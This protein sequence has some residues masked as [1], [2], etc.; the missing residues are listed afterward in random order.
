MFNTKSVPGKYYNWLCIFNVLF[1]VSC[2][3]VFLVGALKVFHCDNISYSCFISDINIFYRCT[4]K[5][6]YSVRIMLTII[7]DRNHTSVRLESKTVIFSFF[8]FSALPLIAQ[9]PA[10]THV[11]SGSN[12]IFECGVRGN[13]K[14]TIFWSLQTNDTVLFPN[15]SWNE[16]H[17]ED[18]KDS[19]STLVV[20]VSICHALDEFSGAPN[21]R[22]QKTVDETV[23][24]HFADVIWLKKK[25]KSPDN[26][27]FPR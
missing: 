10:D 11:S 18:T 24:I 27:T 6:S 23:K 7:G 20:H 5:I 15:E 25:K 1:D 8:F 12:A 22:A 19:V 3:Y 2:F 9:R 21:S 16:F 17:A 26:S 13:P 14:P 4:Y